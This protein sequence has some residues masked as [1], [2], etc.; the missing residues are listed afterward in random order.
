MSEEVKCPKCGGALTKQWTNK[1]RQRMGKCGG[2]GKMVYLGTAEKD[3]RGN[4]EQTAPPQKN[5][6]AKTAGRNR[7]TSAADSSS[8]RTAGT[9]TPG[10]SD[11]FL[12]RV[13]AFLDT[14][15]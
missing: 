10:R 2:C 12:R 9:A 14:D 5:A 13:R 1:R 4:G 7:A 3:S 6:P 11:S 8:R 15:L